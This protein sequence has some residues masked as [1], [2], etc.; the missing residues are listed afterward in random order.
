[1][2]LVSNVFILFVLSS[3]LMY[4]MV[5]KKIRWWILL[6]SSYC[7][8][9]ASGVQYLFFIIFS[10]IVT[11]ISAIAID[12]ADVNE[13]KK[14]KKRLLVI[15]L[16]LNFGSL[17]VVKYT[18]FIIENINAIC[19]MDIP[20]MNLLLPLGISFYTF[21]SSGYLLDVYWKRT[22]PERNIFR[23]G[24]FVSF[25]P[26]ILQGPIGRHARL[27]EQL[28]IGHSFEW[29]RIQSGLERI[30]WG[31]FKKMVLADWAAV[32]VEAIFGNP[33]YYNG[34]AIFGVLFYS[35]QLYA[36]FSGGMDVVI[37]IASLFGIT[38][39][40]NFKRPYFAVSISDF[41]HRWHITLGTWMKDYVFYPLSLSKGMSKFG[42]FGKKVFGKKVGRKLPICLAN[43]IVFFLVGVWHGPAW[44]FIAYGMFS[45]IIIAFSGLMGDQ[46]RKWKKALRIPTNANWYRMFMIL[47]TFVLVNISWF[48]DC[49][50]SVK[51]ALLMMRQAV[52]SFKPD[53]LLLIAAGRE[54]TAF[55]PYVLAII[56]LGCILL[57]IVGILQ[58]RGIRIRET[59]AK[60]NIVVYF[61][62][63]I[64]L[65]LSIGF[66]G[67][68]AAVRGFIYA[69]F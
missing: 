35:V 48:F 19:R 56:L 17:G 64:C 34:L 39:D 38:L 57:L 65:L 63:Y 20:G 50:D 1:M 13:E 42:K 40:E 26:Q 32:F 18:N 6:V 69:Q 61:V 4:Y 3:V 33:E 47:R 23:Y 2:S 62:V 51:E 36:D 5:P 60:Q 37:G 16:L 43:L 67:S 66:F 58:E 68:T 8:Y 9:L 44:K 27:A 14:I 49:S 12:K 21:Q 22:L 30:L 29:S 46:Y 24:L 15:G 52:T 45:G 10:T 53:Q 28:Y 54:G 25:F 59:I 11:Y 7:Y 41:W 55:T 31:F